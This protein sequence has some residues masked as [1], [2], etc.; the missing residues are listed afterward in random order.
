MRTLEFLVSRDSCSE[1]EQTFL[2]LPD[3]PS[4][5]MMNRVAVVFLISPIAGWITQAALESLAALK[6]RSA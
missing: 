6:T 1:D 5:D 4:G 2:S 3:W